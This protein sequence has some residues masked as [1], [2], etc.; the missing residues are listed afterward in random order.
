[1]A[2]LMRAKKKMARQE[3]EAAGV[4]SQTPELPS[5][6]LSDSE[7][8]AIVPAT[9]EPSNQP[10]EELIQLPGGNPFAGSTDG[11]MYREK[12]QQAVFNEWKELEKELDEIGQDLGVSSP[13]KVPVTSTPTASS[14]TISASLAPKA[15]QQ[16]PPSTSQPPVLPDI[17]TA[18]GSDPFSSSFFGSSFGGA[19]PPALVAVPQ[20]NGDT[21]IFDDLVFNGHVDKTEHTSDSVPS[22]PEGKRLTYASRPRPKGRSLDTLSPLSPPPD[23]GGLREAR[24]VSL[25]PDSE[26]Q[27]KSILTNTDPFSPPPLNA[28]QFP[29]PSSNESGFF[30]PASFT[31]IASPSSGVFSP[32]SVMTQDSIQLVNQLYQSQSYTPNGSFS[33]PFSPPAQVPY[34]MVPAVMSPPMGLM[35]P[36]FQGQGVGP[37]VMMQ[38]VPAQPQVLP[39]VMSP[40]A[41]LPVGVNSFDGILSPTLVN[42]PPRPPAGSVWAPQ[43]A[44]EIALQREQRDCMFADLVSQT[45]HPIPEKRKEFEPEVNKV[46]KPTLAELQEKKKKE[47]EEAFIA[48]TSAESTEEK[49]EEVVDWPSSPFDDIVLTQ[50]L[51]SIPEPL[52]ASSSPVST[53]TATGSQQKSSESTGQKDPLAQVLD[54]DNFDAAFQ[55]GGTQDQ[56]IESAFEAQAAPKSQPLP[57]PPATNDPFAPTA[58]VASPTEKTA[59][60]WSLF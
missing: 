48:I 47:Q 18:S 19:N 31:P 50:P 22:T 44:P 27:V 21:N 15:S 14:Q 55:E 29:Q 1:M 37:P 39:D 57:S 28:F 8:Q 52:L 13:A 46:A 12:R 7:P 10:P 38:Q 4:N 9:A 30:Q 58:T 16:E 11:Y 25:S 33:G 20:R 41:M 5:I 34:Q 51:G 43:N 54:L 45:S 42:S 60:P 35:Q 17:M 40:Q 6:P 49:G 36:H 2:R 59:A 3:A 56:S 23:G 32:T 53:A 26:E 24:E